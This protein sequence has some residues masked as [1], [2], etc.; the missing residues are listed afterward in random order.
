VK[1]L[2][3]RL[4]MRLVDALR[5]FKENAPRTRMEDLVFEYVR[6]QARAAGGLR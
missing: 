1:Y 6:S 5:R 4:L 2:L 3:F